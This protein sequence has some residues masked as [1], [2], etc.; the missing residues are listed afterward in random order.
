[1]TSSRDEEV[2]LVCFRVK[3]NNNYVIKEG[4]K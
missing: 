1:M 2:F 3:Y 4:N